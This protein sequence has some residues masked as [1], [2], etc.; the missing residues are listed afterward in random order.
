MIQFRSELAILSVLAAA[1]VVG[2]A[3]RELLPVRPGPSAILA[4]PPSEPS[5]HSGAR[6]SPPAQPSPPRRRP[7]SVEAR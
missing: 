7:H 4:A 1:V 2:T 6:Q 5:G 3:V